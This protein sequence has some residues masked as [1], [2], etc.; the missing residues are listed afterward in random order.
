M[1]VEIAKALGLTAQMEYE[2]DE[3]GA[4]VFAF[5]DKKILVPDVAVQT[6]DEAWQY[7]AMVLFDKLATTIEKNW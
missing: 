7:A 5:G 1:K 4:Y 6:W 3:Y 2:V